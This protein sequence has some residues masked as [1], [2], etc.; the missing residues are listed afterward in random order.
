M[1]LVIR[2]IQHSDVLLLERALPY[3]APE[4]HL[5]RHQRQRRGEVSYLIA[6]L[7]GK[8]VGHGLLK[9]HG[10]LEDHIAGHFQGRCPDLEDLFVLPSQRGKGIGTTLLKHAEDMVRDRGFNQIGLSVN[11][12][13]T[14]AHQL[15]SRLSYHNA[16]LGEHREEGEYQDTQ[17]TTQRWLEI[18]IYLVKKLPA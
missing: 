15:Y 7:D 9:W 18:C 17:G 4:K 13:N 3:G 12:H 6:W 11:V 10:T 8:P 5:D 1:N 2:P 16:G 14:R